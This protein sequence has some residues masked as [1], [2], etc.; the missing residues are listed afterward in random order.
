M[1]LY[2]ARMAHCSV[3]DYFLISGHQNFCRIRYCGR[4]WYVRVLIKNT[5]FATNEGIIGQIKTR[6]VRK[7][8]WPLIAKHNTSRTNWMNKIEDNLTMKQVLIFQIKVI[9][10]VSNTKKYFGI[11][12]YGDNYLVVC[13]CSRCLHYTSTFP[14]FSYYDGN[15][16]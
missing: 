10:L 8:M 9:T 11:G 16:G 5:N 2:G 6:C 7:G 1:Y 13:V 3:W 4:V 12:S 14:S 15:H